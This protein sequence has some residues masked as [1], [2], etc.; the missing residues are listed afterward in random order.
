MNSQAAGGC[1]AISPGSLTDT[2]HIALTILP[3]LLIFLLVAFGATAAE[4]WFRVFAGNAHVLRQQKGSLSPTIKAGSFGPWGV[5]SPDGR[6]LAML[7]WTRNS[8][9]W[10]L[11][12]F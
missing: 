12:G 8:N 5:P 7:G 4:T 9:V 10:M 1:Y 6:H 2:M 11:E 3:V